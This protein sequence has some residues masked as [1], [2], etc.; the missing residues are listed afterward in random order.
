M[1]HRWEALMLTDVTIEGLRGVGR[2]ELRFVPGQRVHVLFGANGVGKTKCLEAL[3]Q[4]LLMANKDFQPYVGACVVTEQIQPKPEA[5][6]LPVVLLGAGQRASVGNVPHGVGALGSFK[7]RRKSY[8]QG[9]SNAFQDKHLNSLGMAGDTREWF[10]ERALSVN[11]YQTSADNRKAEIDAVLSMLHGIEPGIDPEFL[12][13]DGAGQVFLRVAGEKREFG[14][15]S[16]G[17]AALLK[18]VQAIIAG[19]AAFTN[20]VQL[21]NVPGIVLIDEIDAHLH[22]AWQ[23]QIIPRLKDLLPNTTFYI[24]THSPLVL[25]QS[26]NGEAYRLKRGEDGVV[27]SEMIPYPNRR[28]F[29]D[30]LEDGTGVDLNKLKRDSMDYDDQ[31]DAKQGLL[32]LLDSIEKQEKVRQ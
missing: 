21:Q 6:Q 32:S 7:D 9:I 18:M 22:P 10:L 8:F 5:H 24:A 16:S 12:R 2:V 23:A 17:F 13:V 28:L 31:S 19:Y 20:E 25:S 29:A 14:E 4:S 1:A 15:L 11:P 27:R 30:T 26:L 3:Y